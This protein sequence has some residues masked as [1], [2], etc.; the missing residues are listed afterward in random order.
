MKQRIHIL[1]DD[2][3]HSHYHPWI[4]RWQNSRRGC[5]T[6]PSYNRFW[7]WDINDEREHVGAVPFGYTV[8]VSESSIDT[9]DP[10]SASYISSSSA[11][12]AAPIDKLCGSMMNRW[13]IKI[14]TPSINSRNIYII[15]IVC[16]L[17]S[18][19]VHR[20]ISQNDNHEVRHIVLTVL[21]RFS[22]GGRACISSGR[23][24]VVERGCY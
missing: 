18:I 4:W 6:A 7:T 5:K 14:F 17:I 13:W 19:S 10:S 22:S 2:H 15:I 3:P 1:L 24:G 8:D 23:D 11:A 16:L 12:A 9:H 20:C 21:R